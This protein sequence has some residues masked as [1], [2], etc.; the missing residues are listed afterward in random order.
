MLSKSN[1]IYMVIHK[2]RLLIIYFLFFLST[3]YISIVLYDRLSSVLFS[4][5]VKICHSFFYY[6]LIETVC[7][8]DY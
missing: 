6:I 7:S 3:T 1:W 8:C 5:C 4:V 2:K